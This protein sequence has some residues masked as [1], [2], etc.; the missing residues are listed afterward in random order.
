MEIE[1]DRDKMHLQRES[2]A[3]SVLVRDEHGIVKKI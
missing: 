2:S 1:T 3:R